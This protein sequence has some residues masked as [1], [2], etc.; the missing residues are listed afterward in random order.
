MRRW[1]KV[2]AGAVAVVGV[3]AGCTGGET[4]TPDVVSTPASGAQVLTAGDG[5]GIVEFTARGTNGY[6]GDVRVAVQSLTVEGATMELRVALTPLDGD[7][8][9]GVSIYRMVDTMP[10]LSDVEHLKQYRT[11]GL[12]SS[13][14]E[15]DTVASETAVGEPVLYQVWFAAPEDDVATLDLVISPEWPTVLDVP[16]TWS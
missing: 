4:P 13:A 3:L 7:P 14:W 6:T 9:D 12:P 11:L 5:S 16:V 1:R 8:E 15:T 2:V 10:V